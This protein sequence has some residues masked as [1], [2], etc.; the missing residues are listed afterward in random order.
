MYDADYYFFVAAKK[1]NTL[2]I[3]HITDT[4]SKI[5]FYSPETQTPTHKS[6]KQELFFA[7]P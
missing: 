7:N 3:H 5:W 4:D 1:Q 2:Q 6:T